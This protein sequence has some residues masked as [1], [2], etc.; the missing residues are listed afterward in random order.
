[1]PEFEPEELMTW[2]GGAWSTRPSGRISGFSYDTRLLRKAEGFVALKTERR[3]GHDFL[4]SAEKAG[5]SMALVEREVREA[6]LPQLRVDDSW[7]ALQTL[8]TR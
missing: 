6:K 5:A 4:D 3:D 1:M 2:T 7:K 8:A